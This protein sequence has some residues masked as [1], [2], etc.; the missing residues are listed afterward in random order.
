MVKRGEERGDRGEE[1]GGGQCLNR[2]RATAVNSIWPPL[3]VNYMRATRDSH[4]CRFTLQ[5]GVR[6]GGCCNVYRSVVSRAVL[7]SCVRS[8][9]S[10]ASL[11]SR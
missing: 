3:R 7:S 10:P 2:Q 1:E 6:I 4:L 11:D 5:V 8:E 9:D